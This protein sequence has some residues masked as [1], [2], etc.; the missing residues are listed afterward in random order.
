VTSI[1]SS[2]KVLKGIF[3]ANATKSF[4]KN[5]KICIKNSMKIPVLNFSIVLIA[6]RGFSSQFLIVFFSKK[7][8]LKFSIQRN[9]IKF[10]AHCHGQL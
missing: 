9:Q 4:I 1:S 3:F 5:E 2:R 8:F 7:E 6:L 10:G